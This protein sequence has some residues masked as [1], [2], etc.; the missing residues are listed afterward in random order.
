MCTNRSHDG[1]GRFA[2]PGAAPGEDHPHPQGGV[3]PHIRTPDTPAQTY[4]GVAGIFLSGRLAMPRPDSPRTYALPAGMLFVDVAV[5][6]FIDGD[7]VVDL[8][9]ADA[10]NNITHAV[11]G[12]LGSIV[13]LPGARRAAAGRGPH[14]RASLRARG[15]RPR[16]RRPDVTAV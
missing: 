1:I 10:T 15:L 9:A 6:G 5:W 14:A 7:D 11:L 3:H 2:P 13:A 4:G 8:L 16:A 12:A